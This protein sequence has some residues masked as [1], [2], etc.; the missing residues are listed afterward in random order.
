MDHAAVQRWLDNY[1]QAWTT[2]DPQMIAG[3]FT[4]DSLY[5]Y[6]PYGDP[7]RGRKAIVANWLEHRDAPNTYQ[8]HYRPLV[9][10]GNTAIANGRST[11]FEA[12]GRTVSRE[13]DNLFLLRFDE[14]G[15]CREFVEWLMEKPKER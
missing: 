15:R 8:A 11:Y 3:L 7:V 12:D 9:V 1:V 6:S 14:E 5:Y 13:Y 10:E 4:E 2:Y